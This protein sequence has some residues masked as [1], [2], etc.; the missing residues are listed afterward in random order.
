M[1]LKE[2]SNVSHPK[3]ISNFVGAEDYAT[4]CKT[5]M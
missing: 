1:N 4:E 2:D 3:S 5:V